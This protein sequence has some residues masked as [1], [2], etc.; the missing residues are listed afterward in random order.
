M[1]GSV[2]QMVLDALLARQ[3][4]PVPQLG[5][6]GPSQAEIDA[7]LD[8]A[9][10]ARITGNAGRGASG[11]R[12]GTPGLS[13]AGAR[14]W[15]DPATPAATGEIPHDARPAAGHCRGRG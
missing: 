15:R 7:A 4:V 14:G 11:D 8:A 5:A 13:D 10:R 3:S 6:P 12:G 1:R 2:E 9:L